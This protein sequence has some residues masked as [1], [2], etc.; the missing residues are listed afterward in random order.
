M[1]LPAIEC[2]RGPTGPVMCVAISHQPSALCHPHT[3]THTHRPR[4]ARQIAR[5]ARQPAQHSGSERRAAQRSAATAAGAICAASTG[6]TR[7]QAKQSTDSL[8]RAGGQTGSLAGSASQLEWPRSEM[9]REPAI[10]M[11]KSHELGIPVPRT[12]LLP[13]ARTQPGQE[14]PTKATSCPGARLSP[15]PPIHRQHLP[16][17]LAAP[18]RPPPPPSPPWSPL[19]LL[20]SQLRRL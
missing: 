7:S 8:R 6:P 20:T 15:T 16:A 1:G 2:P 12:G 3:H 17:I 14:P 10:S 19:S 5:A 4:H 9:K 18:S 13:L 11:G